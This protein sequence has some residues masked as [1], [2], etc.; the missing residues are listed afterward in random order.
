M[1]LRFKLKISLV[2]IIA[3]VV[4]ERT[5]DVDGMGI[6]TLDQITVVASL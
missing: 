1:R 2:R 5:L 4:I 3:I 6:V